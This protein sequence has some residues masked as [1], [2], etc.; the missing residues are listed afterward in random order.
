LLVPVEIRVG[1]QQ[2]AAVRV[3]EGDEGVRVEEDASG[4]EAC[5]AVGSPGSK[6][7]TTSYPR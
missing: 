5:G 7:R 4:R 2:Q 1:N 3:I 6:K